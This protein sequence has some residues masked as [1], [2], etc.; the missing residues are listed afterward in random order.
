M[1]DEAAVERAA[2]GAK[3]ALPRGPHGGKVGEVRAASVGSSMEIHDFRAY[4]PGDDLR[5]I[6]WNAVARTGELILR[7]RQDEVAPRVEVLVDGSRSMAMTPAKAARTRELALLFSRIAA[8]Q[9]LEPV[10]IAAGARPERTGAVGATAVLRALTF[11]G[12]DDFDAALRRGPPLRSCGLRIALSDFLFE[13]D[14]FRFLERI[15][16]GA[17]ALALV[18]VLDP[19]D[20]SPTGGYGAQLVDVE[21]GERL[22]RILSPAVLR[23]YQRRLEGH[24]RLLR[25]AAARVRATLVTVSAGVPVEA[26]VRGPVGVLMVQG[27]GA[28]PGRAAR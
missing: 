25:A 23:A 27:A 26:L 21:S 6:D 16:R 18:Q 8:R 2:Q 3:L 24:Q 14:F 20:L 12:R 22:E 15:A 1:L 19:E 17:A 7:V 9:G 10:L 11:D 28:E 5:Q 13:I 4:Q